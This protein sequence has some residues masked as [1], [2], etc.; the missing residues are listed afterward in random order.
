[1]A[2][3]GAGEV[4]D[5]VVEQHLQHQADHHHQCYQGG[6]KSGDEVVKHDLQHQADDPAD[7]SRI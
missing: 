5:E 3:G 6:G 2:G 7:F 1:M 4:A